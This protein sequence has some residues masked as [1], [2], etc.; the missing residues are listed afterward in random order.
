LIVRVEPVWL[1]ARAL[2]DDH[3]L[4]VE[5][6]RRQAR[7]RPRSQLEDRA[8]GD[9]LDSHVGRLE[10]AARVLGS[11]GPDDATDA[12]PGGP[13]VGTLL[14]GRYEIAEELGAGAMGHVYRAH[15]HPGA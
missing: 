8:R 5:K 3:L 10:L 4:M 6:D 7:A 1:Q 12:G 14:A 2:R 9:L 13:A 15:E 11:G